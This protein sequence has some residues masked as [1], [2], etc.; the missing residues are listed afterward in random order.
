MHDK[1]PYDIYVTE[2]ADNRHRHLSQHQTN[3]QPKESLSCMGDLQVGQQV[4]IICKS[5]VKR[6][7]RWTGIVYD[8]FVSQKMNLYQKDRRECAT[9]R[10]FQAR[11]YIVK[12][13]SY[14]RTLRTNQQLVIERIK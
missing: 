4:I 7:T 8:K 5:T 2:N 14:T 11:W 13:D 9:K 3:N 1:V 12:S 10:E 6:H